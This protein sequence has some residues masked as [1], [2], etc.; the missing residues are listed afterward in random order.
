MAVE[1]VLLYG[2][3]AWTLNKTIEKQLDGTYTKMLRM[4]LNL[5][6]NLHTT[7]EELYGDMIKLS[8]KIRER[9][10]RF[11]GHCVRHNDEIVSKLVLWDPLHGQSKRGRPNTTYLD[12]LRD[13]T[14]I[15]SS[16]EIKAVMLDRNLWRGFVHQVR[17]GTGPK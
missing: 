5:H 9:R 13:D 17:V 8:N 15:R 6:W 2:C 7:N 11:V 3:E 14:G 1:S 4:V 16:S 10:L 12:M